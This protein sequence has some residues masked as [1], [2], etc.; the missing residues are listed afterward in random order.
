MRRRHS[1]AFETLS[2]KDL[3][4][5]RE[6]C[7][8][9]ELGGQGAKLEDVVAWAKTKKLNISIAAVHRDAEF[10]KRVEEQ[11][12]KLQTAGD[13]AREILEQSADDEDGIATIQGAANAKISQMTLDC[14]LE[15]GSMTLDDSKAIAN[16]GFMISGLQRSEL[17]AYKT[18]VE[19]RAKSAADKAKSLAGQCKGDIAR[20][21]K[22][23]SDEV[24]GISK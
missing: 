23:L 4:V 15:M 10:F 22:E 7:L 17:A 12:I 3:A 9:R 24:F 8:P 13:I 14:L 19:A 6:K 5:Y 20:Q 18:R 11:K 16:L 21:L 1:K 2:E